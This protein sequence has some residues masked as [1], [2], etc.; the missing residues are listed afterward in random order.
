MS[1]RL[2]IV[3]A[4]HLLDYLAVMRRVG[5]PVDR[6]LAKSQLPPQIEQSADFYVSVPLA[7]EWLAHSGRDLE[8]MELGFLA[9]QQASQASMK[10]AH[11]TEVLAAPTGLK[12]LQAFIRIARKE[13][14]NL[15]VSLRRE[16][17]QIRVICD[18]THL[19]R[20]PFI[21]FAEWL[22]LQG[23]ISVLSDL[24]GPGWSPRELTFVSRFTPPD[25]ARAA[26]PNTRILMGHPHTSIL[27][28]AALLARSCGPMA[29]A[30]DAAP[31]SFDTTQLQTKEAWDFVSIL[32][33]ILQPYLG[34]L[35][36]DLAFAADIIGMST[37]TLQRRLQQCG[38]S[39]SEVLQE[40]RF[41]VARSLLD[42]SG[43]KMIDVAMTAGYESQQHFSRAFRRFT[44][45][46]PTAYRRSILENT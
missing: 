3:R 4:A 25:A 2:A 15:H 41:E 37:R 43:S 23:T 1:G 12:R 30:H 42:G 9:A 19:N 5:V 27:I 20:H 24:G 28:D 31:W 18:E 40:A 32:R 36:P 44:G 6:D 26:F 7:M 13:D 34:D 46:T 29:A 45:V 22:N 10:P 39:Y 21:C 14:S 11:L 35:H 33:N 16:G 38:S 8:P 17:S